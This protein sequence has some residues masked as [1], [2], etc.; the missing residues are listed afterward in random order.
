MSS[1]FEKAAEEV[2]DFVDFYYLYVEFVVDPLEISRWNIDGFKSQFRGF[3]HPLVY[4]GHSADF[5]RKSDLSGK[6]GATRH[7]YIEIG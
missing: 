2:G 5:S 3:R 7:R 1:V 4:A 6:S